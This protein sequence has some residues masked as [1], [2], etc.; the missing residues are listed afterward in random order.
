MA[1]ETLTAEALRASRSLRNLTREEEGTDVFLLPGGI[2]GFTFSPG[3]KEMPIYAKQP[4]Q[5]FE[6]H[7]LK[8]GSTHLLGFVDAGVKSKLESKAGAVE[9]ALYPSPFGSSTELVSIDIK[10]LQPAK[11]AISREDGNPLK[12]LIYSE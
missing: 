1:V 9:A 4:Y 5:S 3:Q 12:T 6:V 2:Y 11:K 7:H 8:D 10:D